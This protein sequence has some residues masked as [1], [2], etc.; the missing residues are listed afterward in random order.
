MKGK[1]N[2]DVKFASFL[3]DQCF[4]SEITLAELKYGIANSTNPFKNKNVLESFLTG[5]RF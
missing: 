4:I 2:L 3:P 1:Y 5:V